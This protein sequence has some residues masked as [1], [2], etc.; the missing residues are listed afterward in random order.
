MIKGCRYDEIRGLYVEQL[1]YIWVEDWTGA[2]RTRIE[3][4]IDSFI[5]GDLEYATETV[6]A[7]WGVIRKDGDIEAPGTPFA[8]SLLRVSIL[9]R[10]AHST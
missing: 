6:S 2:T 3:E 9:S 8:V 5:Q 4:K 1:A 10:S 7:L